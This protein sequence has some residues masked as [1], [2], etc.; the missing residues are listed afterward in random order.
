MRNR[1]NFFIC[2]IFIYLG[3]LI[4]LKDLLTPLISG[5]M[6]GYARANWSY[7]KYI[8]KELLTLNQVGGSW[9]PFHPN[10]LGFSIL[11]TKNPQ[12]GP[13]LITLILN[14][15][16]IPLIFIYT[17]RIFP[18]E[19][20][21]ELIAITA[22]IIYLIHPLRLM[23]ATQP[24]SE[25]ISVFFF[26]LILVLSSAEKIKPLYIILLINT[27]CAI[28]FEFWLMIPLI[29]LIFFFHQPN[30]IILILESIL[31]F[32]FPAY[33]MV[34]NYLHLGNIFG[35]FIDKY[36]NAHIGL[37]EVAYYNLFLAAKGWLNVL[38]DQIGI[39]GLFA[40]L[41]SVRNFSL[42][43]F[44]ISKYLIFILLPYYFLALLIFQVYFGSMEW[45][46]PRYLFP[47]LI[48]LIP[49]I[50]YGFL[51]MIEAL[52]VY[53]SRKL[54]FWILLF[55]VTLFCLGD[56]AG[57]VNNVK[58]WKQTS[59]DEESQVLSLI[60]YYRTTNLD[61]KEIIYVTEGDWIWPMFI[62]L[63]QRHD[64]ERISPDEY[65]VRKIPQFTYIVLHKS[66][67][68]D[69]K[70]KGKIEFENEQF[71]VCNF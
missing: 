63:T 62:Y 70:C 34:L 45:L 22:A 58:N 60:D 11:L 9:L 38:L 64:I 46:P 24:L 1:R 61:S 39:T 2:L 3:L 8:N 69:Q 16:S 51:K 21:K 66:S 5:D 26:L 17:K 50:S 54:I 19:L 28:R 43:K 12:L 27:A 71:M 30:K 4:S 37:S 68:N 42:E 59:I 56:I 57:V 29:W 67:E 44:P 10:V 47:V 32:T 36:R 15:F 48:G 55:S 49:F 65:N 6:D 31:C 35:F 25:S 41:Y 53:V 18:R 23:I 40:S 33:W 14:V 52:R 13:R 7:Y 20:K